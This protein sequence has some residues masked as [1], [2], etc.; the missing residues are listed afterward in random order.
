MSTWTVPEAC[1][2]RFVKGF[3]QGVS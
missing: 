2:V 1:T 3:P